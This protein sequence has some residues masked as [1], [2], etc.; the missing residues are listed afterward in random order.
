M[1]SLSFLHETLFKHKMYVLCAKWKADFWSFY[2]FPT[3][4]KIHIKL[5]NVFFFSYGIVVSGICNHVRNYWEQKEEQRKF[6]FILWIWFLL[7]KSYFPSSLNWCKE[8][9]NVPSNLG[10]VRNP[11]IPISIPVLIILSIHLLQNIYGV[12]AVWQAL[13]QVLSHRGQ[14]LGLRDTYL[15]INR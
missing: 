14:A 10:T 8:V 11:K 12:L 1:V 5:H 6:H 7:L 2:C 3:E 4:I 15:G 9:D 13:F